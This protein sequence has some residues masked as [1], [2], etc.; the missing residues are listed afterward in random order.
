MRKEQI[1]RIEIDLLLEGILRRRGYDFRN[2]ARS[3]LRRRLTQGLKRSRLQRL[4]EMIPAIL[5]DEGFF[6]KLLM[7]LSVT[8][9]EMFRDPHFYRGVREIVIPTLKTYPFVKIWCAGCATGEE[10]YSMAIILKEEGF[11]ERTQ[12]YATDIN[13]HSLDIA[14]RGVYPLKDIRKFA[15]NYNKSGRKASLSDYFHANDASAKIHDFLKE[16]I[17]FSHHN[18]VTDGSFG[19]MNL[20]IC[21]NVIIY[22][23]KTLQNRVLTLF[24]DSLCH[25]GFLCL[26]SKESLIFSE[27][28]DQFDIISKPEKIFKKKLEAGNWKIETGK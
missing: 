25:G 28:N 7:D 16:N 17:L 5:H 18:L 9:T 24:R 1:T 21:R 23:N 27:V 26:G 8:V 14:R 22:F 13:T 3:S 19:E 11:Y 6:N 12:I 10:V 2:Y 20:V 4:S 15:D